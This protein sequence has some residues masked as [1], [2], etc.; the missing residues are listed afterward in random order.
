VTTAAPV[1]NENPS[2]GRSTSLVV[3]LL[4]APCVLLYA[5]FFVWPQI[6]LLMLGFRAP[7]GS[8][9]LD[10]YTKFLTDGYYLRLLW[11]T[12]VMGVAT[13]A[14]TILFGVPLAYLLAR[15]RS[16]WALF[17][18]VMTTFPLLVS[19]VVRSFGWMVLLY[20][21]GFVSDLM[22]W[23]YLTDAPTQ[24]MY[25]LPG[26]IIALA[27]VL[28]PIMVLSLYAVFRS[29]SPDLEL[30]AMSLGASPAVAL[31]LVTMK[32]AKGGLFSGSLLVFS[33][34][35]SSFATPSL[36]G[37]PRAAVM[38]TSIHDLTMTVLDWNFAAVQAT[39]LLVTVLILAV[40]YGRLLNGSAAAR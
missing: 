34:A 14:I 28:L 38:A 1:L 6:A 11:R 17:L 21:N 4:L 9:T 32:L 29:I 36:V 16:R 40:I 18:L 25:T 13:T 7:D 23:L 8:F 30:A 26:T 10:L 2:R 35:I 27:Q 37:G 31:W 39:I 12:M 33:M 3:V 19:A 15:M 22:Q 5:I 24:L 20:R